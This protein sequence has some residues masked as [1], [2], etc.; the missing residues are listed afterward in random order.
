MRFR[1]RLRQRKG[2]RDKQEDTHIFRE[3]LSSCGGRLLVGVADGF[4]KPE[5]SGYR[6]SQLVS[7]MADRVMEVADEDPPLDLDRFWRRIKEIDA[8]TKDLKAGSTLALAL[9]DLEE[10]CACLGALGDSVVAVLSREDG[11]VMLPSKHLS[12]FGS[13][14]WGCFGDAENRRYHSQSPEVERLYVSPGD[15]LLVASDGVY[16]GADSEEDIRQAALFHLEKD[17]P[18]PTSQDNA[19][20]LRV[21]FF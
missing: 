11:L 6:A 8:H 15:T 5:E 19:T 4:S 2:Q 10:G 12:E 1:Y 13:K 9:V 3:S 7:A 16:E 18:L 17:R 20:L 21:E 14:L